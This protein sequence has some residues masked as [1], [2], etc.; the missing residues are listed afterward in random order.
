MKEKL[1]EK[2]QVTQ[3][4]DGAIFK[5]KSHGEEWVPFNTETYKTDDNGFFYCPLSSKR[6]VELNH[7]NYR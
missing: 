2:R 6:V 1:L 3:W 7:K 5:T 4:K